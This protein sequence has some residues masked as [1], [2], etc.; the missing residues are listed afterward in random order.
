MYSTEGN[1]DVNNILKL[2]IIMWKLT[3]FFLNKIELY[4]F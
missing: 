4:N 3:S 1:I 2:I